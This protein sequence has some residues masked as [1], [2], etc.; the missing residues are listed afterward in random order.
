MLVGK[1]GSLIQKHIFGFTFVKSWQ[2]ASNQ[3][4]D[5]LA[6]KTFLTELCATLTVGDR[7]K[8][9]L[10]YC[11]YAARFRQYYFRQTQNKNISDCLAALPY[12]L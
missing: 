3:Q 12:K 8:K 4:P 6:L 10:N 2:R 11:S 1:T 9:T 5:D 7:I